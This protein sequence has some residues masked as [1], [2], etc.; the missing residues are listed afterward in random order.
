MIFE[1]RNIPELDQSR[2]KHILLGSNMVEHNCFGRTLSRMDSGR[3][4]NFENEKGQRYITRP[5]EPDSGRGGHLVFGLSK[6]GFQSPKMNTQD[7]G[8]GRA[9]F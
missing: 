1:S 2:P 4:S 7:R 6:I 9:Q 5:P 8:L 3:C